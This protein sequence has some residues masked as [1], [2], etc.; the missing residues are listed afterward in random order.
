MKKYSYTLIVDDIK[1]S[2]EYYKKHFGWIAEKK[3]EHFVLMDTESPLTFSVIEKEYL[4]QILNIDEADIP[5]RSFCTWIYDSETQ[6]LSEKEELL[7]KGMIQIGIIGHFLKGKD[8]MIW[9]LRK[10]GDM[11]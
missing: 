2:E 3:G 5:E 9:E 6:L 10:K 7:R 1:A 11:L 4:F 8:G